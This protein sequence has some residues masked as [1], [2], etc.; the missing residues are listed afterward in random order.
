M[1]R[2]T[3]HTGFSLTTRAIILFALLGVVAPSSSALA[4]PVRPAAP[5]SFAA[6]NRPHSLFIQAQ[7][8]GCRDHNA[9]NTCSRFCEIS[10]RTQMQ[11]E[12]CI[13]GCLRSHC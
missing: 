4:Q 2:S 11:L 8:Q 12:N 10:S 3:L 9:F 7:S 6:A 13:K 1:R 5:M